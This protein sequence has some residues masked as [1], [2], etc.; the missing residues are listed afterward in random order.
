MAQ[1]RRSQPRSASLRRP[2]PLTSQGK[3][4]EWTEVSLVLSETSGSAQVTK[5]LRAAARHAVELTMMRE[6]PLHRRRVPRAGSTKV[7]LRGRNSCHFFLQEL[8]TRRWREPGEFFW[9]SA[10]RNVARSAHSD[11][12]PLHAAAK[13]SRACKL[14]GSRLRVVRQR[15]LA[16]FPP[17]QIDR[18]IRSLGYELSQTKGIHHG[19]T[20]ALCKRRWHGVGRVSDDRYV[21]NGPSYRGVLS[22]TR[23]NGHPT[24]RSLSLGQAWGRH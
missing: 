4:C 24:R 14:C 12:I 15:S 1:A 5:G 3:T 20:G 2:A 6:Q 8:N 9:S 16:L 18:Q 7:H 13:R 21:A 17:L 19:E 22:R 23:R 11:I 10:G